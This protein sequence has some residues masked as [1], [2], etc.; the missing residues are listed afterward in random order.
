LVFIF[1]TIFSF[2]SN[3]MPVGQKVIAKQKPLTDQ[4]PQ[5]LMW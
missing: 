3:I 4:Q 1:G 5:S 2:L